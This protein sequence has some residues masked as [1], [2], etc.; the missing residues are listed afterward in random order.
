MTD[1]KLI[2]DD[3]A[4]PLKE[5]AAEIKEAEKADDGESSPR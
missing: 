1:G 4:E 5:L 2:V 3:F